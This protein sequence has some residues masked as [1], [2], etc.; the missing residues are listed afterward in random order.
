ME[1]DLQKKFT[2]LKQS[3]FGAPDEAWKSEFRSTLMMQV[4]NTVVNEPRRFEF[5]GTAQD[6][7]AVIFPAEGMRVAVRLAT[8]LL[9]AGGLVFGGSITTVSASL[10]SIP[11]DFLYPLKRMT[12]N[13]QVRL[14]GDDTA[15]AELHVEFAGRR[16]QEATKIAEESPEGDKALATVAV[17][18][19]KQEMQT[20]NRYLDDNKPE[21]TVEIAK[22]VDAQSNEH[23]QV[24]NRMEKTLP[25][26]AKQAVQEAKVVTENV[27]VRAIEVMVVTH[28]TASLTVT[29]EEVQTTVESKINN[30]EKKVEELS[31]MLSASATSTAASATEAKTAIDEARELN[32]SGD[33]ASAL[34]KIK[35]SAELVRAV[36][37][38]T[39]NSENVIN[40]ST[41]S[42]IVSP[43][44]ASVYGSGTT[45]RTINVEIQSVGRNSSSSIFEI[46]SSDRGNESSTTP[47]IILP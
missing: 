10:N 14:A 24:L 15:K 23:E 35:E 13:A 16:I 36:V 33:F 1:K 17:E 31:G 2:A 30:I 34:T 27:G 6:V 28:S 5:L 25:T 26:D 42:V 45:I 39:V 29:T 38:L 21:I 19:Y 20:V 32:S 3:R 43:S 7:F 4:K 12:E 46:Q 8:V 22:K 9:L 41:P 37:A 40:S 18:G 44:S 47:R 11:G